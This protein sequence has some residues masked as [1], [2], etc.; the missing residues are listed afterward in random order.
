MLAELSNHITTLESFN[1]NIL[2]LK[3]ADHTFCS[4]AD[5]STAKQ[6]LNDKVSKIGMCAM[7]QDNLMR[8]RNLPLISVCV[9][10]GYAIGGGAEITTSC[11]Y[12]IMTSEAMIQFAH[13]QLGLIPGW[14]GASR[15]LHILGKDKALKLIGSSMKIHPAVAKELGYIE[16]ISSTQN[17]DKSI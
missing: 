17:L 10:E 15:L 6:F 12:R 14:G 9:I 8:I 11:D 4:G 13:C 2:I 7:M 5:L 16:M 3:G 1:G